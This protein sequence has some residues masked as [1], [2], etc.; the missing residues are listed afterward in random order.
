MHFVTKLTHYHVGLMGQAGDLTAD[1][2][3]E[4]PR[5]YPSSRR[6]LCEHPG[7]SSYN[8]LGLRINSN[9]K[10]GCMISWKQC[11]YFMIIEN[12]FKG[13][14]QW[15]DTNIIIENCLAKFLRIS[16]SFMT[17]RKY[18]EMCSGYYVYNADIGRTRRVQ[19]WKSVRDEMYAC[20]F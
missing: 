17:V 10:F 9:V 18:L 1:T 20:P 12:I 13:T 14:S 19:T 7:P 5:S 2:Q 4:R 6:S 11:V 3:S 8:Y 16:S 15:L